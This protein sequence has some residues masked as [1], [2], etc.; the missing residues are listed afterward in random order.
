MNLS[1]RAS[2]VQ[3]RIG[4]SPWAG[5]EYVRGYSVMNAPFSSGDLLGLRVWSQTDFGPYVSVW[6][7]SPDGEWSIYSDGRSLE[8]TCARYWNPAL[9][10]ASLTDIDVT[11]TGPNELRVEMDAPDLVWTMTMTAPLYLEALNAVSS[12]LPLWTWKPRLLTRG[13]E[14]LAKHVLGMGDLDFTFTMPSGQQTVIMPEEVFFIDDADAELDG[15]SLGD[16]VRLETNPTVGGIPLPTR[17][18]FVIG[19]AHMRTTDPEEYR[20]T[21]AQVQQSGATSSTG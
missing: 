11:W 1:H 20:H 12:R 17:P 21:R 3:A 13:R 2:T 19:Q 4:R 7:R 18:T 16:Q 8:T 9:S 6:H 15:R 5:H 10:H 14:W